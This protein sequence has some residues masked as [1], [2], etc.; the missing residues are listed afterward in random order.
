MPLAESPDFQSGMKA[1]IIIKISFPC[2]GSSGLWS[3]SFTNMIED[4]V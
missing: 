2:I 4:E 3:E 1:R